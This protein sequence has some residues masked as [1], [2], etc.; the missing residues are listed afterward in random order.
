MTGVLEFDALLATTRQRAIL[1]AVVGGPGWH[2]VLLPSGADPWTHAW[3]SVTLVA[4]VMVVALL[5]ELAM[6]LTNSALSVPG[7]RGAQP[8]RR[9][10]T[11]P[12]LSVPRA[13]PLLTGGSRRERISSWLS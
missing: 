3:M 13:Y 6:L 9:G 4:A 1:A 5:R 8:P 7:C 2:L 12:C 10:T 11:L